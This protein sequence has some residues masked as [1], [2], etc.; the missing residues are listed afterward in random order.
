MLLI[1]YKFAFKN[2]YHNSFFSKLVFILKKSVIKQICKCRSL[3][4]FICTIIT[5]DWHMTLAR[6]TI[7]VSWKAPCKIMST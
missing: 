7:G 6:H 3:P 5:T 4:Y 1:F 2:V